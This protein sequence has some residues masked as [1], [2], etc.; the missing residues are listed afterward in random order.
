MDLEAL[1]VEAEITL[2]WFKPVKTF[3]QFKSSDSSDRKK[4]A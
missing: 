3:K 1:G 4:T 2:E